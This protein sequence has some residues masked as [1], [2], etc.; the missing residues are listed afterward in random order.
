MRKVVIELCLWGWWIF[1]VELVFGEGFMGENWVGKGWKAGGFR[2]KNNFSAD[3]N[4]VR[5]C[6]R[7][8]F[9]KVVWPLEGKV[10]VQIDRIF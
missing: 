5:N 9:V 8:E 6:A 10:N 3:M 4:F 2:G 1:G 7:I